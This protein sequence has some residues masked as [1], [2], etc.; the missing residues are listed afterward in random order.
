MCCTQQYEI[1]SLHPCTVKRSVSVN[2]HGLCLLRGT[3]WVSKYNCRYL[4][5]VFAW[6]AP[7][8]A[9]CYCKLFM[10]PSRVKF[11][12]INLPTLKQHIMKSDFQIIW[13]IIKE[14]L[15]SAALISSYCCHHSK[16]RIL[17]LTF[18]FSYYSYQKDERTKPGKLLSNF[19]SCSSPLP[20]SPV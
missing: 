20:P 17:L 14:K 5:S 1:I 12:K 2:I 9:S 6:M 16:S 18:S 13:S 7:K 4:M 3:N 10:R 19:C 11:I 15:K 8:M